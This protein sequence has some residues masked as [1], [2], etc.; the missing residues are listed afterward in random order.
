MS[1]FLSWWDGVEA[2]L[3]RLPFVPQLVVVLIVVVPLAVVA[4]MILSVVIEFVTGLAAKV[5]D[6]LSSW[7]KA[8]FNGHRPAVADRDPATSEPVVAPDD[9][10]AESPS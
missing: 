10:K 8:Q 1:G 2:W 6:A 4:A 7:G 5:G 3:I 9:E